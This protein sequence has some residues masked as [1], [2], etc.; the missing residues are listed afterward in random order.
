M[1]YESYV[2]PLTSNLPVGYIYAEDTGLQKLTK[3]VR[4]CGQQPS[5]VMW[6][7]VAHKQDVVLLR[8]LSECLAQLRL[9]VFR[10]SQNKRRRV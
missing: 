8:R 7:A 1:R 5:L 4:A 6:Q 9:L 3:Q 2:V 10:W